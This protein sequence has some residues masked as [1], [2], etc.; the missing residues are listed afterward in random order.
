MDFKGIEF[1]HISKDFAGNHALKDVC[2]RV[3]KGTVHAIIGENGAGKST[4]MNILNGVHSPSSGYM[5]MD[6]ERMHIKSPLDAS[7]YGI[8]MVHQHFM[9]VNVLN[10]W[11]NISLGVEKTRALRLLDTKKIRDS[12][13]S[14]CRDYGFSFRLDDIVGSLPVG[15]QQRIEII[16]VLYRKAEYIILDEPTAVLAP[17]EVDRLFESIEQFRRMGKT[18]L[19][20]S[21][22]IEEVL[23]ISDRISVL[24]QGALIGTLERKDATAENLVSMMVGR[25]INISGKPLPVQKG[26]TI[27]E[28]KDVSTNPSGFGCALK[29]VSF[30]IRKGEILGFAGVDGN[31]QTEL[32]Q[33]VMRLCALHG[34]TIRFKG[35]DVTNVSTGKLHASGVSCIPPDRQKEGLVLNASIYRNMVQGFESLPEFKR[36]GLL[37][38]GKVIARSKILAEEYDIRLTSVYQDVSGLSG[39]NQQKLILARECGLADPLLI[40]AAN[41]TRGLD[42]G[43]IEFVY[44][45]LERLKS[46]GRS[47]L[48]IST[49]LSE[50]LRLSDRIAVLYDGRIMGVFDSDHADVQEIGHLMMGV[51]KER[52]SANAEA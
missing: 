21:H 1:S 33:A 46:E 19:F 29:Q 41:P 2:L 32:V 7:R 6:G 31:G 38:P 3:E 4:L 13:E 30:S 34:G 43:A 35:E 52:A 45:T 16:K 18:I 26:E 44:Q 28:M 49:E 51:R 5:T 22:K 40:V 37:S 9:L 25:E 23:K 42:I 27:L 11:Q 14:I 24:R 12:I 36:A 10:V 48:L 15:E 17:E 47:I 39:G 20:I 50:V 8:G